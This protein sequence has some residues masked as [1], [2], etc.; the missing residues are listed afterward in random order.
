MVVAILVATIAF[1]AGMAQTDKFD[2]HLDEHRNF[3]VFNT[4]NF[5]AS[6]SVL[7]LFISGL[8]L[9]QHRISMWIVTMTMWIAITS[10]AA[11]YGIVIGVF[12]P[13]KDKWTAKNASAI[14]VQLSVRLMSLIFLCHVICLILKL[15]RKVLKFV[16]NVL[17]F[18]C[19]A[20]T[21]G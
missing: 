9:K 2:K 1:Q 19:K 17:K 11:T 10:T 15:A 7:M 4:I 21:K 18:V 8:P 12:S 14:A 5:I 13:E 3:I 16:L 20:F 6:L